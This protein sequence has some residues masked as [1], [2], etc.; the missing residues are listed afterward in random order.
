MQGTK[1]VECVVQSVFST[2]H[3]YTIQPTIT[4]DGRLLSPLFMVLQEANGEFGPIVQKT[5]FKPTNVYVTAS[6]SGKLTSAHFKTW[7]EGVCFL[8]TKQTNVLLLDSWN[9]HCEQD[10]RDATPVGKE[11][12]IKMIPKGTTGQIQSLDVYGFRCGRIML[13]VSPTMYSCITMTLIFI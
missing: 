5:L 6:K 7:L 4:A 13:G 11:I 3:S 10:V 2:T 12:I 1:K 8:K 9:G